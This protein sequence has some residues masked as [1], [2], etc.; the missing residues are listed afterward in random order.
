MLVLNILYVIYFQAL[1]Q[2]LYTFL[3]SILYLQTF[4]ELL[5]AGATH[6]GTVSITISWNDENNHPKKTVAVRFSTILL[7]FHNYLDWVGKELSP[8]FSAFR[9]LYQERSNKLLT[10]HVRHDIMKLGAIPARNQYLYG[11]VLVLPGLAICV[12]EFECLYTQMR[13][14][15]GDPMRRECRGGIYQATDWNNLVFFC[16]HT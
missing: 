4:I 9:S 15:I 13:L 8:K 12:F 2:V 7:F 1:F 5:R 16:T 14:R 11:L 6:Y 3:L 10:G